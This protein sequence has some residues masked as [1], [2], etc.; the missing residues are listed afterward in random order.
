VRPPR[1]QPSV[2]VIGG[3]FGGIATA[4][5]LQRAGLHDFVIFE[6]S[7]GPG[8][9]W[10]DNRYPG[11]ETDAPAHL[12]CF[13][14]APY[15]WTRTHVRQPELLAYVDHLVERFGLTPHFRFGQTITSAVWDEAAQGY[16]LTGA[17]GRTHRFDAVISAVGMFGAPRLPSLPGLAT[18]AGPQ[19][20][21]ASWDHAV[22]LTGR[23]VA[24]I[25]TGSSAAQ[26][27]PT[28]AG[29]A[30]KVLVFQRQP[31]WLLPKGDR[32]LTPRERWLFTRP[33]VWRL[34]RLR[35]YL[36]QERREVGGA[37]FRPGTAANTTA[38]RTALRHIAEVF[39]DHPELAEAVTPRYPFGGKR[40]VL[41][42]QFF[43]SMLRADV[44]LV[45]HAVAACT[46]TGVVD[47]TGVE[48]DVDALVL[49]T[50][51]HA[52]RYLPGLQVVGRDGVDLHAQW[53]GEP[54]AFLG[55]TVPNFPNFFLLY[56]P[57]TN[58]GLIMFNLERQAEYAVAEIRRLRRGTTAV[59]V[60]ADLTRV[61]NRWLQRKLARTSF[62]STDNYFTA[63]SGKVV[64][65]WP[66]CE[67]LYALLTRVLRRPSTL[68]RRS[69]GPRAERAETRVG[70]VSRSRTTG[71]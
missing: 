14:F 15:D 64:T 65:Q 26:V 29:T 47:A 62:T 46:P 71:P 50:G 13:S 63:P 33:L 7:D 59:E 20:H 10:F 23:R 37:F 69:R 41:S 49:A 24:V 16:V 34:N 11:A 25:G 18:F 66:D 68:G 67:T 30:A 38:R 70:A 52:A 42:S 55:I 48:H 17:D 54:S 53:R 39:A 22:D 35:L 56:G 5:N 32:D 40:A 2:A 51:F 45:P 21:T 58:G 36:R 3:G 28:L 6:K 1:H 43:E 44:E 61:Y 31:G 57:N 19:L 9:T 27:V 12:Y 8:G 60:R 4:V